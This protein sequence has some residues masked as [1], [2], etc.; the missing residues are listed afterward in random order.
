MVADNV[1]SRLEDSEFLQAPQVCG[2]PVTLFRMRDKDRDDRLSRDEF[3]AGWER[4][5]R[6]RRNEPGQ[7]AG[8]GATDTGADCPAHF[9]A[10]DSDASGRVTAAEIASRWPRLAAEAKKGAPGA[11]GRGEAAITQ[12]EFYA[13]WQE[14][15]QEQGQGKDTGDELPSGSGGGKIVP[16]EPLTSDRG[17]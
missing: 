4:G 15:G 13:S 9:R 5:G 14:T 2:Q 6:D 12:Q 10:F 11:A 17:R 3:C 7:A 16:P 8:G 1:A